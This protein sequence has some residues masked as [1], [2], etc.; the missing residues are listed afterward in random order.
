MRWASVYSMPATTCGDSFKFNF[1]QLLAPWQVRNAPTLWAPRPSYCQALLASQAPYL[2]D[3]ITILMTR[4]F[5]RRTARKGHISLESLLSDTIMAM[6][7]QTV[8]A[9]RM[10][11]SI[12][13]R[14][15]QSYVDTE[16]AAAECNTVWAA[17]R[18]GH[19]DAAF[20]S[21]PD[22]VTK[23]PA[24]RYRVMP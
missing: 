15:L 18:T 13:Y 2:E 5:S 23:L 14:R 8:G 24:L 12:R 19:P 11:T 20:G 16:Q 21:T 10:S 1:L 7:S 9:A 17:L 6:S 22:A 4:S 3:T